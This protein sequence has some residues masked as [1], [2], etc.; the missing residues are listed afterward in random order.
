MAVI[1]IS[2]EFGSEGSDIAGKVAAELGYHLVDKQTI[3]ALL[4]QYGLVEF[5]KV[6]ESVPAFWE[7]FDSYKMDQRATIINMLNRSLLAMAKH[8]NVVIV[9]RGSYV[10][11]GDFDDVINVRI[12]APFTVR[13]ERVMEREKITDISKAEAFVKGNDRMR[14]QFIESAYNAKWNDA[15]AFDLVVNTAKVASD[16]A[17]DW[18]SEAAKQLTT[19][20]KTNRVTAEIQADTILID[21]VSSVL[22]CSA[23]HRA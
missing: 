22:K 20:K 15:G 16:M 23:A 3:G 18:I 14:E 1:T 19:Q 2:R 8:G 4:S 17:A 12:Q 5:P 9:G 21:A 10:V 7:S 6:Y 13:L 11:L